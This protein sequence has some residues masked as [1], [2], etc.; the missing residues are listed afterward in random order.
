MDRADVIIDRKFIAAM[1]LICLALGVGFALIYL[2]L[3]ANLEKLS[4]E[5]K[6][7]SAKIQQL[8][9]LIESLNYEQ[10]ANLTAVQ[11]YNRTRN[12]VVLIKAGGK[13]GSGFVY[14]ANGHLITNNHV[15][16][17]SSEISVTFFVNGKPIVSKAHVVGSDIYSDIAVIKVD[18][19]PDQS[20]P[21]ILGDSTKLMVGEVVYAI[22][23]P[24]GL[25]GSM[26]SGIVSQVER[27]IKLADLGVPEP[28]GNFVIA[29]VI[30][31]DAAVNPGNSGGPLLNALGEVIGVTFAI[32][33]A[34]EIKAF[35]G[36]GYAIPSVVVSR[37]AS[38]II[39]NGVYWHPWV[40]I[41]YDS[42]YVGGLL[43][44]DVN[45]SSPAEK[46][47]LLKNDI[48]IEVDGQPVNKPEDL[49]IYLE[50]YKSPGDTIT[51]K[52]VRNNDFSNPIS[53]TL[54]LAK[55]A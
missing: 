48:I 35:I 47:G 10:V 25:S 18:Y 29:D 34:E 45:A 21:L 39:E 5:Y 9:S 41:A 20:P 22:G 44:V 38:S 12:S 13:S 16:E 11:I 3:K 24:F 4:G 46:A 43:I 2:D 33:T 8:Q 17:G 31:F 52:V 23:N 15:V 42:N 36:I 6:N 51:L 28:Q 55:R 53:I 37:V 1:I 49:V 54:V 7:L 26:T 32:E 14:D 30:Q 50:R 19:L 27:V 40:G